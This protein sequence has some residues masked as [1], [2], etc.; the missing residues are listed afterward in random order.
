MLVSIFTR[1]RTRASWGSW[2]SDALQLP[3]QSY[4]STLAC[5][6]A[7]EALLERPQTQT[8]TVTNLPELLVPP[9]K[10]Q[11]CQAHFDAQWRA[12]RNDLLQPQQRSL[13]SAGVMNEKVMEDSCEKSSPTSMSNVGLASYT[14]ASRRF[15]IIQDAGIV[16]RRRSF[17]L[18]LIRTCKLFGGCRN[19]LLIQHYHS[20]LVSRLVQGVANPCKP[21]NLHTICSSPRT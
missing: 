5:V 21:E 4:V 20:A 19:P 18:A 7:P 2:S 11:I 15:G 12:L 14:S 17:G 1:V 8:V 9:S 10:P 3:G 13:V 16:L 6:A